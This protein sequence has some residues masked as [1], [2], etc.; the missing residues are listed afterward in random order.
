MSVHAVLRARRWPLI[1]LAQ[2]ERWR[3]RLIAARFSAF[4]RITSRQI[5][6]RR[7]EPPSVPRS[8]DRADTVNC[9]WSRGLTLR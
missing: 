8:T 3:G 6:G 5:G 7:R 1:A 4:H 2:I 9:G